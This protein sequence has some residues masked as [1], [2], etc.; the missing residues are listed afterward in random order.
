MPS[1]DTYLLADAHPNSPIV[2]VAN[3][4]YEERA[5]PMQLAGLDRGLQVG[6]MDGTRVVRFSQ[7]APHTHIDGIEISKTSWKIACQNVAEARPRLHSKIYLGD[8]TNPPDELQPDSYDLVYA[9][10]NTL[11]YIP[12]AAEAL[13]RMRLLSSGQVVLSL[14]SDERFT[15]DVAFPYFASM[16]IDPASVASEGNTFYLPEA[17]GGVTPHAPL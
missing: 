10:N 7:K 11:G 1:P 17:D 14:F 2:S 9:L 16:G 4:V 6:C 13:R 8:I 5:I 3:Y 12:D 15:D